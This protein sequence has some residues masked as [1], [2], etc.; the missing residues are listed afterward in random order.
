MSDDPFFRAAQERLLTVVRRRGADYY[1]R[2]FYGTVHEASHGLLLGLDRW[3]R[4]SIDAAL[5]K[6]PE[7]R[8]M[9]EEVYAHRF[10][11]EVCARFRFPIFE[12][13]REHAARSTRAFAL[14]R[15]EEITWEVEDFVAH[16]RLLVEGPANEY[17]SGKWAVI[18]WRVR[19]SLAEKILYEKF[20]SDP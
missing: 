12:D 15:G 13:S 5:A 8:R 17:A 14:S 18:D 20:W 6:L 9:E 7:R 16:D 2:S 4:A 11:Q 3:D 1:D 10:G 19:S